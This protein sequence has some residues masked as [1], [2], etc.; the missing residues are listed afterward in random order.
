MKFISM[1]APT[2][3]AFLDLYAALDTPA[4]PVS[5]I[6]DI[7]PEAVLTVLLYH[8]TDGRRASNSVVPKSKMKTIQTK[9]GEK[10][11][12]KQGGDPLK[13]PLLLACG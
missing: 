6:E 9:L 4:N 10:F 5:G 11:F 3:D 12:V 2:N 1:T 8:V 7:D 13:G